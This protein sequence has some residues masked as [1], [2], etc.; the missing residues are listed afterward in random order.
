MS[1]ERDNVS[2][3]VTKTTLFVIAIATVVA[4]VGIGFS[5]FSVVLDFAR[6]FWTRNQA[7]EELAN[8]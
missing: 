3:E 4:F 6:G 5:R 2:E 1:A 8:P 7:V